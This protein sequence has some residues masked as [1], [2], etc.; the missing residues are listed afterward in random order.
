MEDDKT[1]DLQPASTPSESFTTG[2]TANAASPQVY[3]PGKTGGEKP[4]PPV[5][6]D[7]AKPFPPGAVPY[8]YVPVDPSG[9]KGPVQAGAPYYVY[10]A[11][12]ARPVQ[13]KKKAAA[14]P[15]F[16]PSYYETLFGRSRFLSVTT[17]V[18]AGWSFAWLL[19][20][21]ITAFV[22]A[23]NFTQA[24]NA[25]QLEGAVIVS[26]QFSAPVLP[27][28]RV[29]LYLLPVPAILWMLAVV[30]AG[31][32]QLLPVKKRMSVFLLCMLILT[33]LVAVWDVFSEK[34]IFIV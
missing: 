24:R 21:V 18:T 14:A 8:Y 3:S 25:L 19:T 16:V 17:F 22:R 29:A 30:D 4:S 15:V 13:Q 27:I 31:K 11:V 32:K 34:L 33:A 5:E 28:L 20:Y 7:K 23:S 10:Y 26:M 9:K 2:D 12:P 6:E 1:P